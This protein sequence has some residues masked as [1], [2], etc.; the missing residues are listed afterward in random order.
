M[1]YIT[2]IYQCPYCKLSKALEEHGYKRHLDDT[3]ATGF[4]CSMATAKGDWS[5]GIDSIELMPGVLK[6]LKVQ[7]L[8]SNSERSYL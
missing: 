5:L 4:T 1:E 8:S 3:A 2:N 7:A 6:S